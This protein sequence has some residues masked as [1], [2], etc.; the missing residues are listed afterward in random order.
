MGWDAIPNVIDKILGHFTP[1]E[2]IKRLKNEIQKLEKERNE[3]LLHK[4][5]DKS[6]NRLEYIQRRLAF[7]NKRLQNEA[8][9]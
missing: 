4:A 1:K 8:T 5:E 3:I 9:D 2:R 6:A 7:L